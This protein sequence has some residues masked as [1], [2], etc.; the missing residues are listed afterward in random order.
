MENISFLQNQSGLIVSQRSISTVTES[1]WLNWDIT[2][3]S[4]NISTICMNILNNLV[5]FHWSWI[6]YLQYNRYRSLN[7]TV[8]IYSSMAYCM[9]HGCTCMDGSMV[10]KIYNWP[11]IKL[12]LHKKKFL[13]C[14]N[15]F[16]FLRVFYLKLVRTTKSYFIYN[17][18]NKIYTKRIHEK[19]S[20]VP[21]IYYN[22][23][24]HYKISFIYHHVWIVF[25]MFSNNMLYNASFLFSS[26]G[27]MRTT[28][29]W[30][31]STFKTFMTW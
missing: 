14:L 27:T 7:V 25:I 26:V 3:G 23:G 9:K 12:P 22:F 29:I 5:F 20:D 10:V 2:S 19:Y 30:F 24:I 21:T 31:F 1:M 18:K 4:R 17:Y 16:C 11:F 8:C 28:K 15:V 13:S 6:H